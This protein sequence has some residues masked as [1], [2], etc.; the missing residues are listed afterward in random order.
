VFWGFVAFTALSAWL[1][2]SVIF[3]ASAFGLLVV[4]IVHQKWFAI[5]IRLRYWSRKISMVIFNVYLA[6]VACST[7]LVANFQEPLVVWLQVSWLHWIRVILWTPVLLFVS[8]YLTLKL[9]LYK[10][11]MKRIFT[12]VLAIHLSLLVV[13]SI[14]LVL[15]SYLQTL[16]LLPIILIIYC[17]V[18]GNLLF[19]RGENST[20]TI[21][22]IRINPILL[23]V[24]TGA[25]L[26]SI[27]IQYNM[28]YLIGGD[29]WRIAEN[30]VLLIFGKYSQI[31]NS[32][33]FTPYP[34]FSSYIIL[35][36]GSCW[37]FPVLNSIAV[38]AIFSGINILSF[39][40]FLRRVLPKRE[41][42]ISVA[43]FLYA[44]GGGFGWLT[45]FLF[46]PGSMTDPN[47]YWTLSYISQDMYFANPRFWIDIMFSPKS[48]SMGLS[49]AFTS[50]IV[51]DYFRSEFQVN[52]FFSVPLMLIAGALAVPAFLIHIMEG[53]L[54]ILPFA[55]I[56]VVT[57]RM[58]AVENLVILSL[59]LASMFTMIIL[60]ELPSR[61]F[62]LYV[63]FIK[64]LILIPNSLLLI[65]GVGV[66]VIG[67]GFLFTWQEIRNRIGLKRTYNAFRRKKVH[68]LLFIGLLLLYGISIG[69]WGLIWVV[70]NNTTNL[71][72]GYPPLPW[73][74]YAVKFGLVGLLA[75][76]YLL[77]LDQE[78]TVLAIVLGIIPI[79]AAAQIFWGIRTVEYAYA[80]IVIVASYATINTVRKLKETSKVRRYILSGL[81]LSILICVPTSYIYSAGVY[82]NLKPPS[83]SDSMAA[84]TV[85]AFANI[86]L[87]NSER[88]YAI[89]DNNDYFIGTIGLREVLPRDIARQ[90]E[91]EMDPTNATLLVQQWNVTY[92]M[93]SSEYWESK[94]SGHPIFNTST[95][96]YS[97]L[98]FMI[99][100]ITT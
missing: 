55:C 14:S 80:A 69:Y 45:G 85:W 64:F 37:G 26:A 66:S 22:S 50:L 63:I 75:I 53:F 48:G 82:A 46:I 21:A 8:G 40:G 98:G 62:N 60:F 91:Q 59:Y 41:R 86:P 29:L 65:L 38:L 12:I 11:K 36:L 87:N 24:L 3:F 95:L 93:F 89:E 51:F 15:I 83:V 33:G 19:F 73:Y 16:F 7:I 54:I 1:I 100:H 9:V 34:I 25:L 10:F 27:G 42:L 67:F 94:G 72:V 57:S 5:A 56:I 4:Y 39:Y 17:A 79:F 77:F 61:F 84:A 58:K 44:I 76:V 90:L 92:A 28:R 78:F 99:L 6:L 30:S 81:L 35:G 13:A 18:V 49:F 23:L 71:I 68:I 32:S 20:G 47:Y 74:Y 52:T 70:E 88:F 43:V 97:E 2:L 96:I 31:A